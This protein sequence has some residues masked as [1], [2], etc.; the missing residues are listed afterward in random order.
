LILS[1]LLT[2][3]FAMA[4]SVCSICGGKGTVA[5][6]ITTFQYGLGYNYR[7]KCPI[8]GAVT[9]KSSGHT[10][11]R[12]SGCGGTGRSK[13]YSNSSISNNNVTYDPDSP[14]GIWARHVAITLRYGIP[15]STE[16][17]VAVKQL[18]RTNSA[19]AKRWM[20]YRE[21]LNIGTSYFNECNAKIMGKWDNV[22]NVDNS[23]RMYDNMLAEKTSNLQI[24]NELYE[25][26]KRYY[27]IYEK[28]YQDYRNNT[29]TFE[30][31][32]NLEESIDD[33]I[34]QK[35]LFY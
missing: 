24:S 10:H 30:S 4:Q 29:R 1:L 33:Y 23:K 31:L 18:A 28:A 20:E 15:F 6:N 7:V 14:E 32:R 19:M 34:L 12:C 17:E 8:C 21:V 35:N 2:T 22:T 27:A 9:L 5:K 25:I 26:Y 11:V 16:E 3:L 13:S